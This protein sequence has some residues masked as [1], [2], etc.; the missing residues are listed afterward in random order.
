MP[1]NKACRWNHFGAFKWLVPVAVLLLG[2]GLSLPARADPLNINDVLA[3][4]RI[5]QVVL[6]PD[7]ALI[8]VVV[9]RGAL[10]GEVY[11][12]TMYDLDPARSDI[13][14]VSRQTGE[15]R[16]IT[17]GRASAAGFWCV[18]WSPDGNR[19]AMLST[20]PRGDEPR[21]GDNVRLH[22]WDRASGRI[23]RVSEAAMMTHTRSSYYRLDVRS[24]DASRGKI[25]R[26]H[27]Y[28]NAPFVWLDNDRL[29]GVTLPAG[30][31]SG[32]IDEET[33]PYRHGQEVQGV[34][35][36]GSEVTATASASGSARDANAEPRQVIL[37][38]FDLARRSARPIAT[39]P[40]HPFLGELTVSV[41]PGGQ[42]LGVL[43][44][45]WSLP[46]VSLG[47]THRYRD[48][49]MVQKQLGLVALEPGARIQWV[50][51]PAEARLPL[52]LL[53][54]SPDGNILAFRARNDAATTATPLFILQSSNRTVRRIGPDGLSVGGTSASPEFSY[55]MPVAWV[56]SERLLARL[57]RRAEIAQSSAPARSDWWL[58]SAAGSPVNVTASDAQVPE[59]LDRSPSGAVTGLF[60]ARMRQLDPARLTFVEAPSPELPD[61]SSIVWPLDPSTHAEALIVATPA[62]NNVR[63]L[64]RVSL[65][66]GSVRSLGATMEGP[67]TV[68]AGNAEA[69]TMLLSRGDRRSL[70]LDEVNADGRATR[71]ALNEQLAAV[72]WGEIRI[73]DYAG[74][75]GGSLRAS[76][77]LPPDYQAGRRYPVITWV[78]PGSFVRDEN[79]YFLDPQMGG[80][81]NLQ[82]YAA[83]GFVVLIPSMPLVRTGERPDVYRQ[84]APNVI[85][86]VD[87]LI[88]LGIADPDRVGI[89]GQSF[90]GYGVFALVTQSERFKAAVAIAGISDLATY[91][92]QFDASARNY[93]GIEHEKSANWEIIRQFGLEAPSADNADAYRR[94]S[95]LSFVDNVSTPL[96]IVHGEH[97]I[98]GQ[99]AQAEM[100]FHALHE[101]GQTARLLR[102]WGEN[103]SISLSPANIRSVFEETISWFQTYLA[104]TP[105]ADR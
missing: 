28:E 105:S 18:A 12:R 20:S 31:V 76:V 82:L 19:L 77:V 94:N 58:L 29:L 24:G 50:S 30:K 21:G 53:S 62:A 3:L 23:S 36:D 75:G 95:P 37:Q 68:V 11:G 10:P 72:D 99:L 96:L 34:L 61:G 98:R 39:V 73:V 22:V 102:Y 43:A 79:D 63:A 67:D 103:H 92:R 83:R 81:Y 16:R 104:E 4:E 85:S 13:W 15:R 51:M 5:D 71:L 49:W 66:D 59:R 54:W 56:N 52:E 65:V 101:R 9:P 55:D 74:E 70:R 32:L 2:L 86:A 89:L 78:Y 93:D 14:L 35:R 26:C 88:E 33:R 44:T 60:G 87:R 42:Q 57:S 6:S 41:A 7:H 25:E 91:Y 27:R 38:E 8:A 40:V 100:F 1:V 90:G 97:D 80:F 45:A 17:D 64:R 47:E 84:I 46:W 48:S 69:G